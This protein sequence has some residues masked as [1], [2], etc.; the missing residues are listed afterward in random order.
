MHTSNC[1]LK[2]IPCSYTHTHI[3]FHICLYDAVTYMCVYVMALYKH[4]GV[5]V[6][7]KNNALKVYIYI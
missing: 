1:R 6:S 4:N 7:H 5:L 3:E 2:F